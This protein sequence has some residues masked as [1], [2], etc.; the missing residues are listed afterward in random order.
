MSRRTARCVCSRSR[1]QQATH[2]AW[3]LFAVIQALV[4]T[5]RL[6]I[7]AHF[8]HQCLLGLVLG[9]NLSSLSF[10][11]S[12]RLGAQLSACCACRRRGCGPTGVRLVQVAQ[13]AARPVD[14]RRLVHLWKRPGHLLD[15]AGQ[16]LRS[17]LVH[18]P[19]HQVVRQAR[20]HPR[21]HDS[22]LLHD[23]VQRRRLRTRTR[24]H[25]QVRLNRRSPHPRRQTRHVRVTFALFARPAGV[26]R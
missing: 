26:S 16:R 4:I 13:P 19:R 20:V 24:T 2:L 17:G 9:K 25:L 23:E 11:F 8:P 10:C 12:S 1:K 5:S 21:R 18:Q 15:A 14:W 7:A 3:A 6:Y 22:L